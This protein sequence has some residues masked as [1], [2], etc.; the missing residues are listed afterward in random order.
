[1]SIAFV[2]LL[3]CTGLSIFL[4]LLVLE[5]DSDKRL[6]HHDL[7]RKSWWTKPIKMSLQNYRLSRFQLESNLNPNKNHHFYIP[8][9][10]KF[11]SIDLTLHTRRLWMF[12][13]MFLRI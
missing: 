1:M 11:A 4:H 3:F 5:G 6:L 12:K 7:V 8:I 13:E 10:L 2:K 9:S